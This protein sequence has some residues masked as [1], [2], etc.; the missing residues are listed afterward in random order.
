MLPPLPPH[1]HTRENHHRRVTPILCT[2]ENKWYLEMKQKKEKVEKIFL[3]RPEV[4]AKYKRKERKE[5]RKGRRK[6]K[7]KKN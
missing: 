4:N 2:S 1:T 6:R 3:K 5:G 7:L